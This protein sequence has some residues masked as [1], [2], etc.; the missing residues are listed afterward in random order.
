MRRI[1][2]AALVLI[3]SSFTFAQAD[4]DDPPTY[5]QAGSDVPGPFTSYMVTGKRK[6]KF[7]CLVTEHDLNPVVMVVARGTELTPA[8]KRLLEKL[9][10]AVH[11]NP[12]TRLAGFVVFVT[13]KLKDFARDDDI[14]DDL[15]KQILD[16][17]KDANLK[18][19]SLA[20]T[21]K[22]QLQKYKIDDQA[23]VFV[24]FYNRYRIIAAYTFTKDQLT[25]EKTREILN[26]VATSLGGRKPD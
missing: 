11:L 15:E 10:T 8:R 12:N 4:K 17:Q 1:L 16:V 22:P 24:L 23:D 14:R 20:L 9:D 2:L 6:G 25:E 7:H 3:F 5:P 18:Y 26:E 21:T 13:D 19:L